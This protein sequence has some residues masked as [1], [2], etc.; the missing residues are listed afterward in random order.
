MGGHWRDRPTCQVRPGHIPHYNPRQG[1]SALLDPL[2]RRGHPK[3]CRCIAAAGERGETAR[4][5]WFDSASNCPRDD[6]AAAFIQ[7]A[8]PLVHSSI[9]HPVLTR[10]HL[11]TCLP[12]LSFSTPCL[13]INPAAEKGSVDLLLLASPCLCPAC[14]LPPGPGNAIAPGQCICGG[15]PLD[16]KRASNSPCQ[17]PAQ[18]APLASPLHLRHIH[19]RSKHFLHGSSLAH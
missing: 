13:R 3:R 2:V 1:L 7:A 6:A 18:P 16:T 14:P 19:V 12:T 5:Y 15:Y 10:P 4:R 8:G 9:Q 11:K 17:S